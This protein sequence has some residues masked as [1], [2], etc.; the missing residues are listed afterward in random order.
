[1]QELSRS[2]FYSLNYWKRFSF[3]QFPLKYIYIFKRRGIVFCFYVFFF[4]FKSNDLCK[5]ITIVT[6]IRSY[7]YIDF[8]TFSF[9]FSSLL[10]VLNNLEKKKSPSFKRRKQ[11]PFYI[12]FVV[13]QQKII[14]SLSLLFRSSSFNSKYI[15]SII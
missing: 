6:E 14:L 7:I 13:L 1:M 11:F 12:F 2:F 4:N 5:T 9:M 3:P 8:L 15:F 10:F